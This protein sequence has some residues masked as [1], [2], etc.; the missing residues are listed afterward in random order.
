MAT[1]EERLA[2]LR[3]AAGVS[4][5]TIGDMLGVTRWSVHNYEA[6]KNRPDYNGLLA[7][8]DYFDVSLDYLVGRSDHREV[9]R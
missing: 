6:G 2:A 9:I 4:Q 7:L 5:Q 8:A 1:F 3:T